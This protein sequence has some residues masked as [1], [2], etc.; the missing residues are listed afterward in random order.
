MLLCAAQIQPCK[1]NLSL[2]IRRHLAFIETAISHQVEYI[3]FPELSLVGYE[4]SLCKALALD[5]HNL[6]LDDF[7][8]ISNSHYIII[9]LGLPVQNHQD[10]S[11]AMAFFQPHFPPK[12]YI[13]EYLHP[14]EEAFFVSGKIHDGFI[15]NPSTIAFGICYEISREEHIKQVVRQNPHTYMASV[16]K[17]AAGVQAANRRLSHIAQTHMF[18]TGMVN[19]VGPSED[20]KSAGGSAFWN[21][22]GELLGQLTH[23]SEGLLILDTD[24]QNCREIPL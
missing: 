20:F 15:G 11:I 22:Q 19:S 4:P 9:G 24:T 14:D 21:P 13:K 3:F 7:Q 10:V 5:P 23:S 8:E 16:A 18:F 2:N 17:D 12:I 6:E 1:G